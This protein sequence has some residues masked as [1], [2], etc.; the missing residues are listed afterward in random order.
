[1]SIVTTPGPIYRGYI[2]PWWSRVLG[3]T[4]AFSSVTAIPIVALWKFFNRKSKRDKASITLEKRPKREKKLHNSDHEKEGSMKR[5]SPPNR[6]LS[7]SC[8]D[9]A[10][11]LTI[12]TTIA[13]TDVTHELKQ[14]GLNVNQRGRDRKAVLDL[15]TS[16]SLRD[17]WYL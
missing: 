4:L 13:E 12:T 17:G 6:S 15:L 11:G 3:W 16:S 5:L 10:Q 7:V 2:F 14:D 9:Q 8:S 1:M